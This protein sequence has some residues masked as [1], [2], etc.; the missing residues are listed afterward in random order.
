MFSSF[1][2]NTMS[3]ALSPTRLARQGSDDRRILP[4]KGVPANVMNP[5]GL[6]L[7][8]AEELHSRK[9]KTS[10]M[11]IIP[12][13][14]VPKLLWDAVFFNPSKAAADREDFL[15][16]ERSY[17]SAIQQERRKK[18][19]QLKAST[20]PV[21][22][23]IPLWLLVD[24]IPALRNKDALSKI[25]VCSIP[26]VLTALGYGILENPKAQNFNEQL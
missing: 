15:H 22:L 3:F 20:V 11:N 5:D 24:I 9:V 21:F 26:A 4:S 14:A 17:A 8:D 7:A 16:G 25:V 12:Y 23:G 18:N 1:S 10:V 19:A 6:T 2:L 13:L